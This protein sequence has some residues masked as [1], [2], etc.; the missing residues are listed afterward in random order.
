M[1]NALPP[2]LRWSSRNG[3]TIFLGVKNIREKT[4]FSTT[5]VYDDGSRVYCTGHA[6]HH[7]PIRRI[8]YMRKQTLVKIYER[9]ARVPI[10]VLNN[11][12]N[13]S[14]V[15]RYTSDVLLLLALYCHASV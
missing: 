9:R 3:C 4:V 1:K 8:Y 13:T 7:I 15:R 5:R 14:Q 10:C 12:N 2:R 11:I 6:C